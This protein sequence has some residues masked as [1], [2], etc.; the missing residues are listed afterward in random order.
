MAF[1]QSVNL[2]QGKNVLVV[3]VHTKRRAGQSLIK[4]H[5]TPLPDKLFFV[6]RYHVWLFPK[7]HILA[8]NDNY[9]CIDG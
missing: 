8:V 2:C 1:Y 5:Q 3:V 9:D 7:N 4:G 6:N